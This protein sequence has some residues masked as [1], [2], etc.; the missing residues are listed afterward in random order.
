MDGI[1]RKK[2]IYWQVTRIYSHFLHE[3]I[4]VV[5]KKAG[6]RREECLNL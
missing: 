2:Y 3:C 5:A 1:G 6:T 4:I